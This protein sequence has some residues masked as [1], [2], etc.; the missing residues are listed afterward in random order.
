MIKTAN[1]LL[2]LDAWRLP[3]YSIIYP[4]PTKAS[5]GL[6]LAPL[7]PDKHNGNLEEFNSIIDSEFSPGFD[8]DLDGPT[9]IAEDL[10]NPTSISEYLDGPLDNAVGLDGPLDIAVE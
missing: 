3:Y 10:N 5:E 6:W 2:S 8:E 9:G 1:N 7:P 4:D